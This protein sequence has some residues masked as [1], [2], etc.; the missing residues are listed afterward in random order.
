MIALGIGLSLLCALVTNVAFL[1]KH[2][3]AVAAP[4][5]SARHPLQSIA[6]LFRSRW[7][8]IGFA[9]GFGAWLLHV[10]ALMVAP[11]SLVQAVIAGGLVLI[12]L[13]AERWFGLSLGRREWAGLMLSAFGLAFL[14]VTASGGHD[15]SDYS[16]S[17]MIAFEGGALGLGIALL[18]SGRSHRPGVGPVLAIA[19][20]LLVG[21]SDVA[22]KALTETVPNDL[23][24]I[25]SPWTATAA[26]ASLAALYA[27]ARALQIGAPIQ[28]IALSSVAANIAAICGGVVV[29]SDPLGGDTLAILARGLAFAAVIVAAALVQGPATAAEAISTRDSLPHPAGGGLHS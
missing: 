5:V 25:F 23:F 11:L 21:V 13:P 2:R 7:W 20:G 9:I 19:S 1:C 18:I 15:S 8:T 12:A 17:A 29:F 10:V 24:A 3:G 6:G 27:I 4:A 14:M 22:I 26:V 28:V 16:T